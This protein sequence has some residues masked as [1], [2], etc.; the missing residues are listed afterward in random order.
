MPT[1]RTPGNA[2]IRFEY[3]ADKGAS[4]LGVGITLGAEWQS[5]CEPVIDTA[6]E[7]SRVEAGKCVQKESGSGEQDYREAQLNNHQ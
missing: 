5:E 4:P 7:R 1:A 6:S 2:E 3:F